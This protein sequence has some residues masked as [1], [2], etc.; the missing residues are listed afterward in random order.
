[1]S[2]GTCAGVDNWGE[3]GVAAEMLCPPAAVGSHVVEDSRR[4][5]CGREEA[6]PKT[7]D[8]V[9]REG[10]VLSAF[11]PLGLPR[12]L[13]STSSSSLL[14]AWSFCSRFHRLRHLKCHKTPGDQSNNRN[15]KRAVTTETYLFDI[16]PNALCYGFPILG[17]KHRHHTK[18]LSIFLV[19][20]NIGS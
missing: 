15:P 4:C 19:T 1:M 16:P 14:P 12:F 6:E 18:K 5:S 11:V 10:I 7:V 9:V 3:L 8:A 20:D 17:P 13:G 2:A